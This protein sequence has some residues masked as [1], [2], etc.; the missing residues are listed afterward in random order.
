MEYKIEYMGPCAMLQQT[1]LTLVA[2]ATPPYLGTGSC[3]GCSTSSWLLAN[4]LGKAAA[5]DPSTRALTPT[6]ETQVQHLIPRVW[7]GLARAIW[8]MKQQVEDLS[9]YTFPSVI[10]AFK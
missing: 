10:L 7:P 2:A 1:K 5:N 4:S 8:G 9:V 6:W 3:P